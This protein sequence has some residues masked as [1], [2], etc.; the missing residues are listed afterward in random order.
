M[1]GGVHQSSDRR[2]HAGADN[3]HG[4]PSVQPFVKPC[5]SNLIMKGK[6]CTAYLHRWCADVCVC[7]CA[8]RD[9]G[10][11]CRRCVPCVGVG[12]CG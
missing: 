1:L 2:T 8:S 7:V 3:S 6:H 10:C 9:G 5:N 4:A 12:A 11:L